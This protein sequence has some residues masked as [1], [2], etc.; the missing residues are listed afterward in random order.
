ML[1]SLTPCEFYT[2][3]P[4]PCVFYNKSGTVIFRSLLRQY[5]CC[6][7]EGET[8]AWASLSLV[9]F[10]TIL[11]AHLKPRGRKAPPAVRVAVKPQ[12]LLVALFC[13]VK[14]LSVWDHYCLTKVVSA[15]RKT[16]ASRH[17][18]YSAEPDHKFWLFVCAS[19]TY[20]RF[21]SSF[22]SPALS[23][24]NREYDG[25]TRL[26]EVFNSLLATCVAK[27]R[28]RKCSADALSAFVDLQ[29]HLHYLC[30]SCWA[31][32]HVL[33]AAVQRHAKFRCEAFAAAALSAC[34]L[35]ETLAAAANHHCFLSLVHTRTQRGTLATRKICFTFFHQKKKKFPV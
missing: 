19:R 24:D 15:L 20:F 7:N 30:R 21:S 28:L 17:I 22:G 5:Y 32:V 16:P 26:L 3:A 35:R 14:F 2:A 23:R 27:Q 4:C 9:H 1:R 12:K 34:S 29:L 25:F 13:S 33:R 10:L 31:M 8:C 11:R 6:L 18:M